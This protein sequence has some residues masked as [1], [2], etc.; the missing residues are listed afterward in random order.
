MTK[1]KLY[2][3]DLNDENFK[4]TKFPN[5]L[6]GENKIISY[7]FDRSA[8]C[9]YKLITTGI[10]RKCYGA[11]Y[12]I[13]NPDEEIIVPNVHILGFIL[14]IAYQYLFYFTK[15]E[16]HILNLQNRIRKTLYK[17]E[18]IINHINVNY[19]SG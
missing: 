3:V 6:Q 12:L 7:K 5:F 19:E 1:N 13:S 15:N 14:E 16:I 8:R 10:V 18:K 4:I 17:T 11:K 9:L 2:F